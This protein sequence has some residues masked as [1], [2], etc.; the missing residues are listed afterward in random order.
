[1][2]LN[3]HLTAGTAEHGGLAF[4]PSCP[5]CRAERL[6]GSLGDDT[7][8][9]R[10]VPAALVAGLLAFS[11]A[12]P[13]AAA[14][15]GEVDQEQEGSAAPGG[16]QPGL[17]P[18]FDPGGDDALDIDTA[19]VDGSPEAGGQEDEGEGAPVETEPTTDP[20]AL[21]LV[22]GEPTDPAPTPEHPTAP[23]PVPSPPA[24]A[25]PVEPPA[26]PPAAQ[27]DQPTAP[28]APSRSAE[29]K[30]PKRDTKP[31]KPA[32]QLATDQGPAP[33][34]VNPAP[35]VETAAPTAPAET[36]TVAQ[37]AEPTGSPVEGS[38]YRIRPGDSLWSIARRMLGPDASA[39]QVAREVNRLWE[40]NQDRIGTGNP[41]LIYAGTTL[42]LK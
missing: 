26:P 6:A 25:P 21:V 14:Q 40:L 5:R 19:P 12:A 1:V 18:D 38:S 39:G 11:A 8:V 36:V 16:D 10:R 17:E 35:V 30:S 27:V 42:R 4:H 24:P 41:S 2:F 7:L 32:R 20:D 34:P 9:S 15:V 3:A 33:P 31:Q 28:D 29:P 13:P 37:P 22:E 23:A